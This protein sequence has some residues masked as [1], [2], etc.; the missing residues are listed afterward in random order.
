MW[1][2]F[3]CDRPKALESYF[4]TVL[5]PGARRPPGARLGHVW[6]RLGHVGS[7][8]GHVRPRSGHVRSRSVRFGHR[9]SPWATFQS[10]LGHVRSFRSRVTL[11]LSTGT[12]AQPRPQI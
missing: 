5:A 12:H 8:L 2:F 4:P 9:A 3:Y 10:C 7:R 6:S 11:F 1:V